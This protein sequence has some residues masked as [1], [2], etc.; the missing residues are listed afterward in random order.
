MMLPLDL[1]AAGEH[2]TLS[3]LQAARSWEN[4]KQIY[5]QLEQGK[6]RHHKPCLLQPAV[7]SSGVRAGK[8]LVTCSCLCL[9]SSSWC[10][11]S[12]SSC[13]FLVFRFLISSGLDG[14]GGGPWPVQ[15]TR[16]PDLLNCSIKYFYDYNYF[17]IECW[18]KIF[19]YLSNILNIFSTPVCGRPD[20]WRCRCCLTLTVRGC[21]RWSRGSP[22]RGQ[23]RVPP[24]PRAAADSEPPS[25]APRRWCGLQWTHFD[26]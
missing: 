22:S 18:M 24:P 23:T 17:C 14:T 16:L 7:F 25:R 26:R 1:V 10:L 3:S 21:Y 4:P 13:R 20:C 19:L 8:W 15:P 11:C 5:W 2:S 12:S 6:E 9:A